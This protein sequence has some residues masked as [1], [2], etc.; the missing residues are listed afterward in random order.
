MKPT[1][2]P[3]ATREALSTAVRKLE[4]RTAAELVVV[5]SERSS[6]HLA[7]LLAPGF[8]SVGVFTALMLVPREFSVGFIVWASLLAFTLPFWVLL[9]LPVLRA[10]LTP[11]RWREAAVE[12]RAHEAF[13]R[14][15]VWIVGY[16]EAGLRNLLKD[17]RI[18]TMELV[19]I[20]TDRFFEAATVRIKAGCLDATIRGSDGAPVSGSDRYPRYFS[21]YWTFSRPRSRPGEDAVTS[22]PRCA[23]PVE[24]PRA[25]FCGHCGSRIVLT[26]GEWVLAQVE[27]ADAYSAGTW[28]RSDQPEPWRVLWPPAPLPPFPPPPDTL[29]PPAS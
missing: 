21:E 20:T 11:C 22:C 13:S 15:R 27:Q 6:D 2:L 3:P 10:H 25:A 28:S 1:D 18:H 7:P 9:A 8:L 4:D 24:D 5:I 26:S 23:A 16:R 19:R 14:H 12:T 29:P 17:W